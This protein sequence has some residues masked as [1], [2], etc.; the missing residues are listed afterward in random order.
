MTNGILG[1][2]MD[3]G[4]AEHHRGGMGAHPVAM[5]VATVSEEAEV[6][7]KTLGEVAQEAFDAADD[8][9]WEAAAQ[10]AVIRWRME[11][12]DKYEAVLEAAWGVKR[13]IEALD[14]AEARK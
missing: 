6:T 10:A 14:K 11:H 13:A 3:C 1:L 9:P 4:E 5:A 8:M 7:D 2:A 12:W